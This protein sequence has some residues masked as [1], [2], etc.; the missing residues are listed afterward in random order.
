[1][2]QEQYP[3]AVQEFRKAIERG[4]HL[5]GLRYQLG[6]ALLS[7]AR[8]GENKMLAEKE[9]SAELQMNPR[10][11]ESILKLAEIELDRSK[12]DEAKALV[13]RALTI[14][15]ESAEAHAA[16]G[17]ILEQRGDVKGATGELETAE[18]LAPETRTTR[19]QLAQL[20][21]KQG[22]TADS[23]REAAAFRSLST[24]DAVPESAPSRTAGTVISK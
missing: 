18:R 2:A 13:A 22:R 21:R 8:T 9:F 12:L 3:S 14:R 19:Y 16:L 7:E 10:H 24:A 20:Y 4:P 5:T 23:D 1:M 15:P 17:K 6:E 11:V